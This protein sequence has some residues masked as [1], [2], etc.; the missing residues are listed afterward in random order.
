MKFVKVNYQPAI[1]QHLTPKTY[2]DNAINEISLVGNIQDNDFNNHN[3]TEIHSIT[4]KTLAVSV[5]KVITKAYVAQFHND[6]ERNRRDVGLSVY[7][8]EVD[9]VKNIQDNDFNDNKLTNLDSVVVNGDPISDRE[10][11][12][13]KYVDNSVG[14]N[15]VL[16]FNQTL[17]N[18]L[19]VSV[20]NDTY[21]LSK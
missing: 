12:N 18:Y 16:R 6:N 19:K 7:N 2:V 8:K 10:L 17:E 1:G 13:K 15:N 4:L 11:A 3:L 5:N 20:G 9:L 14:D 21:N